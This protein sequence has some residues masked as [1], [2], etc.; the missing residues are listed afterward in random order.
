MLHPPRAENFSEQWNG[1]SVPA[2]LRYLQKS[3]LE[4]AKLGFSLLTSSHPFFDQYQRMGKAGE[5]AVVVRCDG[6]MEGVLLKWGEMLYGIVIL[7]WINN[8]HVNS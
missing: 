5:G 6:T 3:W 2:R 4:K 7:N 1:G 8:V